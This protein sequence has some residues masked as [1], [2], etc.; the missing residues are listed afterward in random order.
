MKTILL[1]NGVS[2]VIGQIAYEGD[3]RQSV[4]IRSD[5]D[6][7]IIIVTSPRDACGYEPGDPGDI[8]LPASS[9]IIRKK[10]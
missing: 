6:L 1:D 8:H 4:M 7:E 5:N 10:P 3:T 2:L 9:I